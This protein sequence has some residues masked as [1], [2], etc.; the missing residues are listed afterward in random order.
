MA[1]KTSD[2]GPQ[3]ML[4]GL[5]SCCYVISVS[6][7]RADLYHISAVQGAGPSQTR[8]LQEGQVSLPRINI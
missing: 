6:G 1:Q 3:E 5:L 2:F 8:L 4:L 7:N